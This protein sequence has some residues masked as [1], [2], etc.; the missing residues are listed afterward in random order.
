[1]FC[2][3]FGR[4][5]LSSSGEKKLIWSTK[6]FLLLWNFLLLEK[7]M[8]L[9]LFEETWIPFT[10]GLYVLSLVEIGMV[11]LEKRMKMWKVYR[12]GQQ[13]V[14]IDLLSFQL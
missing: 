3:K 10:Q 4:N 14:R 6:Y 7:G 8:A 9:N 13:A 12:Q 1:M 5:W 11:V 2:A